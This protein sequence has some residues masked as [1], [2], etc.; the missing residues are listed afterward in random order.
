[1]AL[2]KK[3]L[4]AFCL[5]LAIPGAAKADTVVLGSDYLQTLP[6]TFLDFGGSIGVVNFAGYPFGPGKTDTIVQRT[7]DVE[8]NGAAGPLKIVGL[9][10]VSTAP[11]SGFGAKVYVSLDPGHLAEDTGTISIL[12]S[13]AKGGTFSS[14]F[15]LYFDI[16]TAPGSNGV[17]CGNGTLLVSDK[18]TFITLA[19]STWRPTPPPGALIVSGPVGDQWANTHTG[20]GRDQSDFWP[21]VTI[22][23]LPDGLGDHVIKPV[24]EPSTWAMMLIGFAGL[25]YAGYRRASRE[26]ARAA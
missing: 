4:T 24:P 14:T 9:S 23:A 3:L 21:N 18:K 2:K 16:C 6:G 12:G 25:G 26:K 17:G 19:G 10:L 13:A 20:L 5:A 7:A 11:V 15:T 8:I 1:M 22:H